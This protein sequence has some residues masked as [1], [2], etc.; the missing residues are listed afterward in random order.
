MGVG[1]WFSGYH[2]SYFYSHLCIHVFLSTKWVDYVEELMKYQAFLPH[3][4][5][6][7]GWLE[8]SW[9]GWVCGGM[10]GVFMVGGGRVGGC[11]VVSGGVDG[12]FM[13]R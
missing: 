10:G 12:V 4:V 2:W 3:F 13:V 9:G 7:G 6:V 1:G 11:V 5:S 8:G